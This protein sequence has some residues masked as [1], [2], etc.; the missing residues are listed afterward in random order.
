[1]VSSD[2]KNIDCD[3]CYQE[4]YEKGYEKPNEMVVKRK[5]VKCAVCGFKPVATILYGY[6]FFSPKLK[7]EIKVGKTT[8]GGCDIYSGQPRWECT[9][10]G[11]LFYKEIKF[12]FESIDI[13]TK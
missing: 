8:L 6:P 12:N 3:L 1:M 10:C 11:T 7:E 4:E 13:D 2:E 5:P 9:K